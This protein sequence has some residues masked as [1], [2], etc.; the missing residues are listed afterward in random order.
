MWESKTSLVRKLESVVPKFEILPIAK[1]ERN[2]RKLGERR[3]KIL[4]FSVMQ[5]LESVV[6]SSENFHNKNWIFVM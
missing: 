6:R 5:K 2:Y 3:I 1:L 4:K